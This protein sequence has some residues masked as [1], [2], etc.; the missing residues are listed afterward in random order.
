MRLDAVGI[1]HDVSL[2]AVEDVI[3]SVCLVACENAL[4]AKVVI[5]RPTDLILTQGSPKELD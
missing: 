1:V 4:I 2:T 3:L 5:R